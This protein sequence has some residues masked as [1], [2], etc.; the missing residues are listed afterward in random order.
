MY[1]YLWKSYFIEN[2]LEIEQKKVTVIGRYLPQK[3]SELW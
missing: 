3:E 1:I 2:P